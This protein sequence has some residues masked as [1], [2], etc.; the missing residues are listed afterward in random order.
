MFSPIAILDDTVTTFGTVSHIAYITVSLPGGQAMAYSMLQQLGDSSI[1]L[2]CLDLRENGALFGIEDSI[3]Y[4]VTALLQHMGLHYEIA[5]QCAI[6]SISTHSELSGI[7]TSQIS[8]EMVARQ[9]SAVQV[10][11]VVGQ[12]DIIVAQKYLR[13][14]V[15][16]LETKFGFLR[17]DDREQ[18]SR[19]TA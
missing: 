8:L 15:V 14:M 1:S 11:G 4:K 19:V 10:K 18:S 2:F 9:I 6:V 13:S 16:L 7:L 3:L 5:S 17:R 12:L